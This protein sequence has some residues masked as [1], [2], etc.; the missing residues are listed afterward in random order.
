MALATFLL[1]RCST[2][3]HGVF[4]LE[5]SKAEGVYGSPER[6]FV[7]SDIR[8]SM[9]R[10]HS[11]ES[12]ICSVSLRCLCGPFDREAAERCP[13]QREKGVEVLR[14]TGFRHLLRAQ[15]VARFLCAAR[16]KA[17]PLVLW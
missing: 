8:F 14:W 6:Q 15:R 5:C 13:C 12:K 1:E 3:K 9:P 16:P 2:S 7:V 17:R 11:A 4:Y 10:L